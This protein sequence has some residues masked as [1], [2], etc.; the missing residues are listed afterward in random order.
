MLA[1]SG[2]SR[3]EV[4]A[5]PQEVLDVLQFHMEGPPP[6]LPK[7]E[8]LERRAGEAATLSEGDPTVVFRDMRKLGEGAS[9][10]VYLGTDTR[11]G[12][13]VAIKQAPVSDLANL[14]N[15]I[16]LRTSFSR[17]LLLRTA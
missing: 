12:D 1:S 17:A 11:S 13:R 4:S 10:T 5:H 6:K 14:R 9:G 8:S 2:I 3:D 15:E 7:R 16:A